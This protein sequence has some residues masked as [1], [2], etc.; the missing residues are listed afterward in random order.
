MCSELINTIHNW[1]LKTSGVVST[2]DNFN[3]EHLSPT[4]VIVCDPIT[5][6]HLFTDLDSLSEACEK[7]ISSA[8]NAMTTKDEKLFDFISRTVNAK[9]IEIVRFVV[10]GGQCVF[11]LRPE[12]LLHR[13][14][15]EAFID[16][17]S[18]LDTLR[19]TAASANNVTTILPREIHALKLSNVGEKSVFADYLKSLNSREIMAIPNEELATGYEA[20]ALVQNSAV[21]AGKLEIGAC[22]GA[23]TF[24]PAPASNAEFKAFKEALITL[25]CLTRANIHTITTTWKNTE[26]SS[27]NET[28][29]SQ[30][31]D[32]TTALKRNNQANEEYLFPAPDSVEELKNLLDLLLNKNPEEIT[33]KLSELFSQAGWN[34]V[35]SDEGNELFLGRPNRE[36]V[37]ARVASGFTTPLLKNLGELARKIITVW[38]EQGREPQG[39]LLYIAR[40]CFEVDTKLKGLEYNVLDF[41]HRNN[42]QLTTT[43]ELASLLRERLNGKLSTQQ[44][45]HELVYPPKQKK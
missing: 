13:S 21:A 35:E 19:P 28:A 20:L 1:D 11:F 34:V 24:L 33:I 26:P 32:S 4:N 36:F 31:T 39:L 18:W 16:N 6:A 41:A 25:A 5:I 10:E 42:I 22:G 38:S 43:F 7:A 8:L 37:I 30:S 12:F 44:V 15:T 17:Y 2:L 14:Q 40:D 45:C 27:L 23:I 9:V 3:S 29:A